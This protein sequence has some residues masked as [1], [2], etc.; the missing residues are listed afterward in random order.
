MKNGQLIKVVR[1]SAV[2]V[3]Q[4]IALINYYSFDLEKYTVKELII[5][6]SKKYP[7][8]WLPLAVLEAIYQG[9]LKAVSVE[10]ILDL[11]QHNG[12]ANYKFD[13]EFGNLVS[14][15]ILTD[16]EEILG[17]DEIA[18]KQFTNNKNK[19]I[20][21]DDNKVQSSEPKS[22]IKMIDTNITVDKFSIKKF[23]PLEDYSSCY[24]RLK[25]FVA[26]TKAG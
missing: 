14:N 2:F 25:S 5:K 26:Q 20:F 1:K 15:N 24:L 7:H 4:T 17:L 18:D 11:W 22:C 21:C 13:R 16:F 19:P 23:E 3:N 8:F 6:W 9:R 12:V 10:K